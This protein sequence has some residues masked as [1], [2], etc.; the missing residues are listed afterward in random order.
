MIHFKK[1]LAA[2]ALLGCAAAST[3][4]AESSVVS[5]A[6]DSVSA[7][8]A[9]LSDSL[10]HSSNSS[11]N[12]D[13]QA[14]GDYK[15]IDVAEVEGKPGML[16]LHLQPTAQNTGDDFLLLLPREAVQQGHVARDVV[17]TALQRPYGVAFASGE[18]HAAFFLALTDDWSREL[19]TTA[20]TL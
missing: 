2:V 12:N 1:R 10:T 8:S 16:Q 6:S 11:S 5:S 14:L 20:V 9:K 7:S 19:K 13:R 4:L 18:P 17:V 15:V 3:C